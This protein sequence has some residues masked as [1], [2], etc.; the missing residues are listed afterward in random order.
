MSDT[1][2][3]AEQV[4]LASRREEWLTVKEFAALKRVHVETVKRW[5]RQQQVSA[6][7]TAGA[8][9]QLPHL[10]A[11]RR[12]ALRR[13]SSLLPLPRCVRAPFRTPGAATRRT[14]REAALKD[15]VFRRRAQRPVT[16]NQ[17]RPTAG[18]RS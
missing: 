12:V 18:N 9:G 4:I 1:L 5:I 8:R 2:D 15:V 16:S 10:R 11:G 13:L 3:Q 7:R 14:A 6:E 17:R